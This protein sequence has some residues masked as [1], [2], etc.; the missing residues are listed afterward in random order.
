[1]HPVLTHY[2][3]IPL[4]LY[5]LLEH[6]DN[7]SS[8]FNTVKPRVETNVPFVSF[9]ISPVTDLKI[10]LHFVKI[11]LAVMWSHKYIERF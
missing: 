8:I 10:K 6:S 7:N 9:L 5:I 11:S 1:M 2:V 4:L 3:Y